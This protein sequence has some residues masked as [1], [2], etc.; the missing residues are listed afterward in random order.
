[1]VNFGLETAEIV[2]FFYLPSHFFTALIFT[3]RS[4]NRSQPNLATSLAVSQIWECTSV[5]VRCP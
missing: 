3:R 5:G 1:M 4:P 2:A